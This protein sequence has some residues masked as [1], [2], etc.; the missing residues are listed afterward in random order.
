M[1][2]VETVGIR[3]V[4]AE[5]IDCKRGIEWLRPLVFDTLTSMEFTDT[6]NRSMRITYMLI[7]VELKA[8]RKSGKTKILK[9]L[10]LDA[11]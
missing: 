6:E 11:A 4:D 10:Q 7:R 2:G 3:Y 1:L 9:R 8:E 5:G